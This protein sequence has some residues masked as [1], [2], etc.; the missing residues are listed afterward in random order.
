LALRW[1]NADLDRG[2]VRIVESLEQT[3]SGLRFKSPKTDRAR[4]VT[5]PSFA[6][7]ESRRLKREQAESLLLLGVRQTA[8]TLVCARRDGKPLQPQ[9]L[10]HE[11]PRFLARLGS[12]FPRVRFHDLRHSHATQLLLAGVH[13]KV[14]QERLGHSTISTTLDLYS[15]VTAT[16][17]EDAAGRLDAAFRGAIKT[18]VAQK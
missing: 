7:E 4:A 3:K 13:P 1:R 17:Q 14:A 5:L 10:T 9:S 11:F 12:D 15:H 2:T 16:M 8:D 6:V 18:L